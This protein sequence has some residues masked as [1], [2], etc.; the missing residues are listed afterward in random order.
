MKLEEVFKALGIPLA[1]V[2]VVAALLAWAG[3]TLDQLYVVV[4][5]MVGLQ[6]LG[7]FLVDVLKYVGVVDPETSGKWS[8]GFQLI[9]LVGVAIY[10]KLFPT[11]DVHAV[12]SH[13]LEFVKVASLVFAY[14]TQII[15]AK[16]VH[17]VALS[18]IKGFSFY[19]F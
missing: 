4:G 5:S 14:V 2:A 16:A 1:L 9:S 10:L 12:D 15:G 7:A 3:M 13:L 17:S 6:L 18:K 11:F 19:E 8:A